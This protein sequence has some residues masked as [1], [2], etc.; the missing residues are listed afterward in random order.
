MAPGRVPETLGLA[1]KGSK[2]R[3]SAKILTSI[4]CTTMEAYDVKMTCL[5]GGLVVVGGGLVVFSGGLLAFGSGLVS[6]SG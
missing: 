3:G 6:I 2:L 5:S 1:A 4:T